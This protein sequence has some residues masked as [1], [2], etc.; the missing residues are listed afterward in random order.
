MVPIRQF[1]CEIVTFFIN[2]AKERQFLV[3]YKAYNSNGAEYKLTNIIRI[4]IKS[5]EN[6]SAH[7][8]QLP[9]YFKFE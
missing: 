5:I 3:R 2:I 4:S 6:C 9:L 7:L 8:L 1:Q